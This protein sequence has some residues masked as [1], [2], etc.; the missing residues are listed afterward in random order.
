VHVIQLQDCYWYRQQRVQVE[1]T[2]R[3]SADQRGDA[4]LARLD[5]FPGTAAPG[6]GS[7]PPSPLIAGRSFKARR[8]RLDP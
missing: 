7:L 2:G 1:R 8:H 6:C 4:R 5:L 3:T